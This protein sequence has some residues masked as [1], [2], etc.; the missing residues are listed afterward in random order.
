MDESL[1]VDPAQGM[2]ADMELACVVG[3]NNGVLE[4]AL[5]AD[6]APQRP[7]AGN[8]DGVGRDLQIGEA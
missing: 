1:G 2:L 3:D 6:R 7:F 8:Q 5:M 4:Q